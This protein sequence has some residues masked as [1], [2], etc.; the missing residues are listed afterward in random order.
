LPI[1][2]KNLPIVVD[3][4]GPFNPSTNVGL[5]VGGCQNDAPNVDYKAFPITIDLPI[6]AE[7]RAT[8]KGLSRVD[9]DNAVI[10]PDIKSS[11]V[12]ACG[13]N[14]VSTAVY[15]FMKDRVFGSIRS[16]VVSQVKNALGG[17]M[18]EKPELGLNPPCPLGSGPNADKSRCVTPASTACVPRVLGIESS[19][20]LAAGL[21]SFAPNASPLQLLMAAGGTLDPAPGRPDD[22]TPYPGHTP[23][24][25]TLTLIGGAAAAPASKCI[26]PVKLTVPTGIPVLAEL[27]GDTPPNWSG[28][29]PHL[30]IGISSRF[31]QYVFGS[32]YNSGVLCVGVTTEQLAQLR[33][34]LISILLPSVGKLSIDN[35]DAPI[36]VTTRPSA[37]P[38]I[39]MGSGKDVNTDPLLRIELQKFSADFNVWSY[40]RFVRIFT[41]T[42]DITIPLN[43]ITKRDP[44]TNPDGGLLPS[45]GKLVVAN[46]KVANNEIL[47]ENADKISLSLSE[48]LTSTV[49]QLAG[50]LKP[51]DVS[52]FLGSLGLS[53]T[54]PDNGIRRA[55]QG[56]E[57]FLAVYGTFG[58]APAGQ[59]IKMNGSIGDIKFDE[60]KMS[61]ETRSIE[62]TPS[63]V[64]TLDSATWTDQSEV[65]W[66]IDTGTWSAWHR[67][68]TPVISDSEIA[69]QGAHLLHF[70]TR[71]N[72]DAIES[73]V[74]SLPFV[75]DALPP[76]FQR[77]DDRTLRVADVVSTKLSIRRVTGDF[78]SQWEPLPAGPEATLRLSGTETRVEARDESGNVSSID[79]SSGSSANES[80]GCSISRERLG[81]RTSLAGRTSLLVFL[82]GFSSALLALRRG[83]R[84]TA[85]KPKGAR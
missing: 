82:L 46:A 68:R 47:L 27:R 81:A 85:D 36:S 70:E 76:M 8:R 69:L 29:A 79:L 78:V 54:I 72:A 4:P 26:E 52:S 3:I 77:V 19:Y 65:R 5:G 18:C 2:L 43:L 30:G 64:L 75:I 15:N 23:N 28:A 45:I 7:T 53:L 66:A 1:R 34:G 59:S 40:D 12:E 37:P 35:R 57:D 13:S 32:A 50:S 38:K 31:I 58:K 25:I 10:N 62:S 16:G 17:F 74:S 49:N 51:I 20:D 67:N 14:S 55:T 11:D 24:G 33:S 71:D 60:K 56:T 42:A 6:V 21:Q 9:I 61:L 41:F 84:T 44:K 83:K 63:L 22:N 73:E 80:A 48:I 39:T